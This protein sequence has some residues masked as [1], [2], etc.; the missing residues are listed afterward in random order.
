[1]SQGQIVF[2]VDDDPG[3]RESMALLLE[4]EGFRVQA[5]HSAQAF[6]A[7]N[8]AQDPGCLVLDLSMPGMSGIELQ[9]ALLRQGLA[10]PI[11]FLSA[12][13]SVPTAV[14]AIKAG[15][16]DFLEKPVAPGILVDRIRRALEND[17][18]V[19]AAA[20]DHQ[21]MRRL[22]A[23]L[24]PREREV[25]VLAT[26]GLTNKEMGRRL[27]ISPRT[28]ENHRARVMEKLGAG[29]IAELCQ[30]ATVCLA[31]SDQGAPAVDA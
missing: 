26:Q 5:F 20:S 22:F 2:L 25:M 28:V 14:R 12:Y 6:L 8:C 16:V 13:G 1:M 29:S 24:T 7:A 31:S 10:P 19:R 30:V 18:Q 21:R 9:E 15:A 27:G 17:R 3:L 4:Q 23:T 11:I